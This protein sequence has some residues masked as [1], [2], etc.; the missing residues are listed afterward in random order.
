MFKKLR[1]MLTLGV[2]ASMVLAGCSSAKDPAQS[3]SQTEPTKQE[4]DEEAKHEEAP[5]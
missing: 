4:K 3:S 5:M 2:V 1:K